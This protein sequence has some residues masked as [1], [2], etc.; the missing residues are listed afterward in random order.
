MKALSGNKTLFGNFV[1]AFAGAMVAVLVSAT[2]V[3]APEKH[4]GNTGSRHSNAM[5]SLT[6]YR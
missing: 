6:L 1:L 5:I 2:N 3:W 4:P